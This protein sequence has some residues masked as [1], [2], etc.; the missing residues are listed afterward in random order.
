M[1]NDLI[2]AYRDCQINLRQRD[3]DR[4]F[5]CLF[6][7]ESTRQH[8][9]A[10]YAF[11]AEIAH[12][13]ESVKEPLIGEMRLQWWRD[14]LDQQKSEAESTVST[15]PTALAIN[16]TIESFSL[17]RSVFLNLID[18]RAF[19]IYQEPMPSLNELEG[20]CG[21][22]CSVLF[23]L[24]AMLLGG[25]VQPSHELSMAAGHGGVAYAL[26]GLLRSFPWHIRRRRL[27]IP[28]DILDKAGVD[29]N[30]VVE[31]G[32]GLAMRQAMFMIKDIALEHLVA[33]EGAIRQLPNPAAK[34]AFLP[35]VLV[36]SYLR[37]M[38]KGDYD[39]FSTVVDVPQWRKQLKL[40]WA[41]RAL[42]RTL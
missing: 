10:L 26:T 7:P 22:T 19:D 14:A 18:A 9:M 16:H 17:P 6:A 38:D 28:L 1:S 36:R 33:A 20:Y 15:H 5:S 12:I 34:I 11:S 32:D 2:F 35:L 23:Q 3:P 21:E 37:G 31:G 41:A 39:P 30:Q 13:Q 42:P 25:K 24:A 40:W 27:Y 4:Y 29:L 8:L